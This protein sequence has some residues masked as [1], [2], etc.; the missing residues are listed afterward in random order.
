MSLTAAE[1]SVINQSMD[2]IHAAQIVFATQTTVEA[3]TAIRNYEQTRDALLRSY[4]WTFASARDELS[5]ISTLTLDVM[6][7]A[8]WAVGDTI[9]GITSGTTAEILTV[10]SETEY[11][12][13]H[14]S[15]D[16]TD[17]ET[18][19]NADD[20]AIVYWEGQPLTYEG[21]TVYTYDDSDSYQVNCGTG[22]PVVAAI[23]PAFKWTYQYQ[24]PSDYLRL[25]FVYE[26][27]GTDEVDE[28]WTIEGGR[29]LTHYDTVNIKYVK[30][31]TD[32]TDF[33]PLF[34]E[35]LILRLALKLFYALASTASAKSI[36]DLKDEIKAAQSTARVVNSQE[37]NTTGRSNWNLARYG[38]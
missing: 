2:R 14:L 16:F 1:I 13:I 17:G 37:N 26:D 23:T 28:R 3:L 9:T 10:T 20:V 35:F 34:T 33:D 11:E 25:I 36:A 38:S 7:T 29:I 5:Q 4:E 27:D 6:P 30:K 32:P 21:E 8:A 12:I 31:V 15:G 19:T 18:I 22:Y 24:L